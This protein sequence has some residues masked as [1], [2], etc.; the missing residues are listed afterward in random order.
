[1]RAGC[2]G[3]ISF[4]LLFYCIFFLT[5]NDKF[6]SSRAAE[7]QRAAG[8]LMLVIVTGPGGFPG[9]AVAR[10]CVW[11]GRNRQ[12]GKEGRIVSVCRVNDRENGTQKWP[13]CIQEGLGLCRQPGP[14]PGRAEPTARVARAAARLSPASPLPAS[15]APARCS[16]KGASIL[17]SAAV[18]L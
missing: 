4:Y 11:Q 14:G 8:H 10:G 5:A 15:P 13:I 1:M 12:Q 16:V 3:V 6:Q 7:S 17:L 2:L 9:R 18:L